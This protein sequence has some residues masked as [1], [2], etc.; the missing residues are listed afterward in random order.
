MRDLASTRTMHCMTS[1]FSNPQGRAAEAAHAYVKAILEVVGDHDPLALLSSFPSRLAG[2]TNDLS[3]EQLRRPEREGKW[4][5]VEVVKHIAD[6]ELVSSFRFRIVLAQDR[7][8]ITGFDQDAWAARLG[9]R[10]VDL[11]KTL[12]LQRIVREANVDLL[13]SLSP[14]QFARVGLHEERGEE[15]IERLMK[16]MAGHDLIHL[17][18]IERIRA[19][20]AR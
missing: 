18:Q 15:S 1:V 8:R 2:A 12:E 4:S 3:D 14:E 9:Y 11:Q 7:P 16:L 5:I 17:R 13:R 6:A 10:N 20:V 19:A